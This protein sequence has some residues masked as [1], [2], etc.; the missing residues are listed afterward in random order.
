MAMTTAMAKGMASL[1][2]MRTRMGS[3][4][5]VVACSRCL[6]VVSGSGNKEDDSETAMMTNRAM[7]M[8][9]QRD[10]QPACKG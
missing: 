2:V 1:M 4:W 9:Q 10:N 8:P 6:L 5:E 3:R 7:E